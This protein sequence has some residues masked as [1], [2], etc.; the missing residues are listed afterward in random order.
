[1][2]I[3]ISKSFLVYFLKT[4]GTADMLCSSCNKIIQVEHSVTSI[5]YQV[6][7]A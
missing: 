1:M 4:A 7:A 5:L 2:N 3:K 6:A